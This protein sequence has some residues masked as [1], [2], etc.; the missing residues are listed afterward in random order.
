MG[1]RLR[2]LVPKVRGGIVQPRVFVPIANKRFLFDAGTS[3]TKI[4]PQTWQWK[5]KE[6][7]LRRRR[8]ERG[9]GR[10]R[11]GIA[12]KWVWGRRRRPR[13]GHHLLPGRF[14]GGRDGNGRRR[15]REEKNESLP[16]TSLQIEV[17]NKGLRHF[18]ILFPKCF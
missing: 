1:P 2:E 10:G 15:R 3:E 7:E 4:T 17:G 12:G 16:E 14:R 11:T 13:P 5:A 9:G 8:G 6:E 18:S